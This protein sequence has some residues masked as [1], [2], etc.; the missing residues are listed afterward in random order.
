MKTTRMIT[1]DSQIY[2]FTH[3]MTF[4][5]SLKI[6]ISWKIMYRVNSGE[7]V[8]IREFTQVII[9]VIFTLESEIFE[10]SRNLNSEAEA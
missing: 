6:A 3:Y 4:G 2:E 8:K 1:R 7:F 5:I 9:F 10:I